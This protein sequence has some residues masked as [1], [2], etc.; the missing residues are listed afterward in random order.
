MEAYMRRTALRKGAF[1]GFAWP[2]LALL[3]AVLSA[4]ALVAAAPEDEF[5]EP[6]QGGMLMLRGKGVAEA[7]PA[8][9]LGTDV[10]VKVS[11]P[12]ARF[13]VTQAFRN[14]SREWMEASYLYPLPDD[15]AVDELKMVVGDRVFVGRIKPREEAREI[16]EAALENGQ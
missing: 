5:D 13:T 3:V 8:V 1:A 6:S 9:R 7:M 15:G 2:L 12:V 4:A 10:T 14:T 11:G 16:Y